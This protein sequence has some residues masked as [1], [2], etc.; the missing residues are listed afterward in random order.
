MRQ[1]VYN[2]FN[3]H[4]KSEFYTKP[5]FLVLTMLTLNIVILGCASER[6]G[7]TSDNIKT[8]KII[9]D[10][11]EL[12]TEQVTIKEFPDWL[13]QYLNSL[14]WEYH[15]VDPKL[16]TDILKKSLKLGIDF[17][18]NNQK[19]EGNFNYRYNFVT[20]VMDRGDNQVRQAGA[21]WALSLIYQDKPDTENRAALDKAFKFFFDH[22]IEGAVPGSLVIAYPGDS[23]C[24]TNTVALVSLAIIDYLRTE[25]DGNVKIQDEYRKELISKLNGYIE[26]LKYMRLYNMHF[27]SEYN[28]ISQN[29]SSRYKPNSDGETILC[30]VKAAKY[31]GYTYLI[32]LIEESAV[33]MAKSYTIDQWKRNP[34]S[35]LTKGFFHWSCM[36]FW[37]Y[38]DAGWKHSDFFSDYI[39]TLAWWMIHTHNTLKRT[40]N[41]AYAYEGII[42]AYLIAK[43]R[44]NQPALNDL[45][46][47]IDKGLYK[48][49]SW[50]VGGPLEY[51]NEFLT[52]IPTDYPISIGG[53]MNKRNSPFL[54][55][56]VTQHQMHTVIL[57]LKYVYNESPNTI[58]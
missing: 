8:S 39:L 9:K 1:P 48:L 11:S 25:K 23:N 55:I 18:K 37:E 26:H 12:L 29:K 42:H 47:T 40:K 57:A 7:S 6:K 10:P 16:S 34:D 2:L 58:N 31:L 22:T 15:V 50:Q 32:P 51:E 21:L 52:T 38:Q 17:L 5:I 27:S 28:L 30:F 36:A 20:R 43:K 19:P 54:R 33:V 41:T 53:I 49:T 3:F 4:S 56:D 45:F 44:D 13:R 24:L 46:Y 35:K 14:E